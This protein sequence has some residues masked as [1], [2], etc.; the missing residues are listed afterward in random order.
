MPFFFFTKTEQ[1]GKT[2]PV[3]RVGT[4]GRGG[5][6][7]ERDQKVNMIEIICMHVCKC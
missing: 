7:K 6:Y 3:W 1:E 2:G 4:S 5:E